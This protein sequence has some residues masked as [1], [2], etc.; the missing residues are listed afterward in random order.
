MQVSSSAYSKQ[1]E[2]IMSIHSYYNI[3]HPLKR[4]LLYLVIFILVTF[5]FSW[6]FIWDVTGMIQPWWKNMIL[7]TTFILTGAG[8]IFASQK[9]LPHIYCQPDKQ[10]ILFTLLL[11]LVQAPAVYLLFLVSGN[12]APSLALAT[13]AA[14][15]LP[16]AIVYAWLYFNALVPETQIQ[17]E[18]WFLPPAAQ[19][20]DGKRMAVFLKS[21]PI[22]L[23]LKMAYYDI[24]EITFT[25]TVAGRLTTGKMFNE[26]LNEKANAGI[27]FELSDERHQPFGWQFFLHRPFG[28]TPLNPDTTL[29]E[30]NLKPGDT[31]LVDRT[32]KL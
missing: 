12:N 3:A 19:I 13:G 18:P 20:P 28:S 27:K 6:L 15:L 7:V 4:I 8:H 21:L 10:G 29:I 14:F 25:E 23:K 11:A 1:D 26:F 24:R 32:K 31:I 30:N 16:S 22:K 5:F 17:F 2:M 9:W